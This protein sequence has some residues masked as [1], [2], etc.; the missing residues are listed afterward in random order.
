MNRFGVLL[1][2]NGNPDFDE[3]G[4]LRRWSTFRITDCGKDG[5]EFAGGM[6]TDWGV[7]VLDIP[8]WALQKIGPIR[9]TA[10]GG[11][12]H[13]ND[14]RVTPDT[15]KVLYRFDDSI[16]TFEHRQMV[17][18]ETRTKLDNRGRDHDIRIYGSLASIMGNRQSYIDKPESGVTLE[19]LKEGLAKNGGIPLE[20]DYSRDDGP[21]HAQNFIDS[22][23]SRERPVADIEE[24]HLSTVMCLLGNAA[25]RTKSV[26]DWDPMLQETD[27]SAA[28]AIL[29]R[30]ERP[31]WRLTV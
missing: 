10:E 21:L 26:V 25:Y 23:R 12:F 6:V 27:N 15:I 28:T 1:N 30:P 11:I 22:I 18:E 13:H 7:H 19:K 31:E 5:W 20:A 17:G 24:G 2:Q 9:V 8:R 29:F 14:D 4:R 3:N 16:W